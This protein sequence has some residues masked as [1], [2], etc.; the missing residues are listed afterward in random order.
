MLSEIVVK[1]I[2]LEHVFK[3]F[4]CG[5]QDLNDFL[6]NDSNMYLENLLSVTYVFETDED[7]VAFSPIHCI[8]GIIHQ[9]S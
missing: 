6:L 9:L 4:D 3:P 7:T 5:N 8:E 2:N 1:R